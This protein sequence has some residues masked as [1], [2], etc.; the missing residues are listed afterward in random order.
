M[1]IVFISVVCWS[2]FVSYCRF[3]DSDEEVKSWHMD[4]SFSFCFVIFSDVNNNQ[5]DEFMN[6]NNGYLRCVL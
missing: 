6:I 3:K 1:L 2:H 5:K 4:N